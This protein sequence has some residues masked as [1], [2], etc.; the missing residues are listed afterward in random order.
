MWIKKRVSG[1]SDEDTWDALVEICSLFGTAAV[2]VG[3][4]FVYGYPQAD[5]DKVCAHLAHVRALP[6]NA[7]QIY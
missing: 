5:D 1:A 7:T 4:H 2:A 6:R 3:K